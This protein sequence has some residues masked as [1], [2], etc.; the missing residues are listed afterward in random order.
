M[1]LILVTAIGFG[2][3]ANAQDI[4]LKQDGSE[5]IAKVLE[6][7]DQQ[8]KYKEFDFQD[9]PTRNMNI[10]EIFMITYLCCHCSE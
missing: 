5:I 9:G 2:I 4:I 10:S 3:T 8:I 1:F 6:V 7:T